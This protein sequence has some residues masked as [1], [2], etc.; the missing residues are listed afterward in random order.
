MRVAILTT[1]VC[2]T[3]GGAEIHAESLRDALKSRGHEAEIVSI[4]YRWYPPEKILDGLL[5][6]RLLDVGESNGV[7]V[8]RV[9]GL[10]FPAYHIP[11]PNKVLWI[12]HQHRTAFDL[13]GGPECDLEHF[14]NGRTVREAIVKAEKQLIPESRAVYANSA[15]VA[16]RLKDFCGLDSEPLYHPPKNAGKFH[17]GKC[18]DYLFYPS[19]LCSLKRQELVL[20]ALAKT[21]TPARVVFSGL[22]DN[23]DYGTELEALAK[24]LRV[25]SRV[26]WLGHVSDDDMRELYADCRAVLFPP[27]DEDYGYVTLEAMLSSKAVITCSDSGGPLEFV[28]HGETGLVAEPVAESLAVAMDRVMDE[29]EFAEAAGLRGRE[30]YDA[31]NISWDNVIAKLLA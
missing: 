7:P 28:T 21:R 17:S 2:F 15:N 6:C 29:R 13:W 26:E 31:M 9:I 22:P 23:P 20:R 25:N 19:R 3:R 16:R 27:L 24:A 12:L 4:P 30:R 1:Q 5:A 8:D 18:G 10:R 14:D 11:H